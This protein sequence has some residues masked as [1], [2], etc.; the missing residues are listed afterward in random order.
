MINY[1]VQVEK[2][3]F[4]NSASEELWWSRFKTSMPTEAFSCSANLTWRRTR[5]CLMAPRPRANAFQKLPPSS[6]HKRYATLGLNVTKC[7][8]SSS[9][10]AGESLSRSFDSFSLACF[11]LCLFDEY[12]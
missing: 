6:L 8:I 3:H 9:I 4:V 2:S 7:L 10:I 1:S 5:I 12:C 11:Y